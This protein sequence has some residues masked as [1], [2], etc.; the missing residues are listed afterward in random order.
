[1]EKRRPH[2]VQPQQPLKP[3]AIALGHEQTE[4]NQHIDDKQVFRNGG[5]R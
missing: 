2:K 3:K 5:K 4:I 1:M